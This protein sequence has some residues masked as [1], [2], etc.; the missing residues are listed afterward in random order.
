MIQQR[1]KD[2][3]QRLIEEF[4]SKF[5]D[6]VNGAPFEHPERKKE[7]LN[8]A[9]SFFSTHFDTKATDNAQLLAEKIKDTDLLQQYAKLLLLKYELIDLKEPEQLR[10][11]LDIVIY[12]EN[13]DKTFSWER[14]ILRED[15]LRLLDEDN[16][17]N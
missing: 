5:N 13:T 8:E 6:L 17:Y 16:R 12:L 3:L 10:T 7:L 15:L 1:K 4:F 9:L 2:Y 14:D 11:A